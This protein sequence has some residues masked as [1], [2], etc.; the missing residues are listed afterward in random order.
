MTGDK[1]PLVLHVINRLGVGGLENGLVNLINHMPANRYRHAIACLTGFD[2]NFA[3]RI[4]RTDVEV[5]SIA[6]RPGKDPAAYAR[7]W[8]LLRRLRPEIVHT[9]NLGTVDLQW[10]AV[11]AGV[12]HRVHGEHGWEAADPLGRNSRNLMVRR[13]CRPA[14]DQ[15]VPMSKDIGVWLEDQVGVPRGRITQIYNGVDS[16]RFQPTQSEVRSDERANLIVV[17]TIGRLDPVKNQVALLT[18]YRSIVDQDPG[19]ADR[20]RLLIVGGG[21]KHLDLE[22]EARRLG[23]SDK[24]TLT[25]ECDDTAAALREMSIFALPSLNEGISNT[26]LESMA[27]GLPAVAA[28]VGGNPEV[29][30]D[31]VTGRLYDPRYPGGLEGSLREYILNPGQREAH[32]RAARARALQHFSMRSMVERYLAL[33]DQM[34]APDRRRQA[35]AA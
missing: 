20:L 21:P 2:C 15:F 30:E 29:V 11:M 7:F 18:A 22:T 26:L 23:I 27:S 16:E 31:G 3:R 6:K 19:L 8:R 14:I 24:V 28:A 25:G 17:G 35:D 1:P 5:A 10:V 34:L 32:G 12:R 13:A 4:G 33:Y 9:R